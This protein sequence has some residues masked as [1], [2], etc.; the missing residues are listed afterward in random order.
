MTAAKVNI[1]LLAS[2]HLIVFLAP[3][4][5]KELHTFSNPKYF[6]GHESKTTSVSKGEKQCMICQFDPGNIISKSVEKY[7]HFNI[8]STI[9]SIT[10]ESDLCIIPFLYF[11]LRAPP[12]L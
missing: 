8:Y 6:S 1:V 12:V 4:T 7:L 2:F 10:A 11:A 9:L 3:F 5:I